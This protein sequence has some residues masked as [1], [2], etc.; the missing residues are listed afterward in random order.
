MPY[1]Y[2][3]SVARGGPW[4][5]EFLI[6]KGGRGGGSLVQKGLLNFLV[7]NY[8]SQRRPRVSQPVNAGRHWRGKYYF[9]SEANSSLIGGYP[10]QLH[11]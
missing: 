6:G 2:F 9:A 1:Y 3:D 7:T 8:F 11:F 10:K 4:I 5:Q